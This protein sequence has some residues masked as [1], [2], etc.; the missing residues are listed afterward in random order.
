MDKERRQC[1]VLTMKRRDF[2]HSSVAALLGAGLAPGQ[3]RA[4]GN[5]QG[6]EGWSFL[7]VNDLHYENKECAPWFAKVV[8]A[9]KTSAPK[10]EFI[11]LG[12]DQANGGKAE[13]FAPV[14]NLFKTLGIPVYTTI[15]NHDW[16]P[17][18]S[19]KAYRDIFPGSFNQSFEHRGW[20]VVGFDS[21]DGPRA[22]DTTI[23]P[24]TLQWLDETLPKLSKSKPTILYTHFPLGA[25][26]PYRPKNVE[27]VLERFA[28]YNIQ[29]GFSGHFH[30][31]QERSWHGTILTTDRC[32][33]RFRENHDGT[34]E[35]GWFVCEAKA[36]RITRRFVE[37][38]EELRAPATA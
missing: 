8:A 33:S 16:T 4:A 37:I 36:G 25:L 34:K 35:K 10:A 17:S 7:A 9:M 2:L 23:Q 24:A 22:K 20:Q 13:Q 38:P 31:F 6:E 26:L 28:A 3:L 21:S 11:I 19:I 1:K 29:A 12:G 27:A 15:G 18:E 5:G 30:S 14:R 32:C